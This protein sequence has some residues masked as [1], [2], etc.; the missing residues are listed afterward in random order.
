METVVSVGKQD[1]PSLRSNHYFYIDKTDFIKDWWEAG[2][3]ITLITRPRRFGKT[4]NMSMLAC[5]FSNK[6][7]NREDLFEG[8]HIWKDEKY[9]KLQGTYPVIFLSFAS[10]KATNFN[11]TKEQIKLQLKKLYEENRY[12]LEG[13][14]LSKNEEKQFNAI[15]RDPSDIMVMDA[16]NQLCLYLYRYYKKKV[17]VL[18]DEYDTP[19]QEA[20]LGGYWDE[21]TQFIRSLFNSAFKTN[22][23]LERGILTGITRISKESI[24]SDLNNLEVV[25]TTSEKYATSFGFTEQEVFSALDKLNLDSEK[26]RVKEWYDGFTFGKHPD[27]YNPWSITNFLDKKEYKT[28]WASSSSNGLINSLIQKSSPEVKH[29]MECLLKGETITVAIDEQIIF[30]Q[31]D[32]NEEAIWSLMLASGY[33]KVEQLQTEDEWGNILDEPLYTLRI[34]NREVQSMFIRMMKGWFKKTA[35][36]YNHFIKS[37][38]Q[39]DTEEMN[40]YMNEVALATF[41][42]F[43]TGNHPS[44][45]AQ[46]E[47]FYHGFVLGLLVELRGDYEV[48]SNNESGYGRYD[49]MICPLKPKLPAFILEFKIYNPSKEHSLEDTILSAHKQIEDRKYD[50]RLLER[51]IKK[52]QIRHYGFAFAGKTVLIG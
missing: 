49:V 12:L 21:F 24:F 18:L 52:E 38:L 23:Y 10:V 6:Y 17:I 16:I 8:L 42:T 36:N 3:D 29:N 28:Y 30:N 19:M 15:T 25:T 51:G 39:G 11:D 48:I 33:L 46:P 34:T 7:E 37:M 13:G 1:F 41:S 26:K 50:T 44:G 9:R 22:P 20:Y 27:I 47:R 4:L 40:A 2:D 31:L 32:E 43:D 5:F 14:I 35:S 45:K